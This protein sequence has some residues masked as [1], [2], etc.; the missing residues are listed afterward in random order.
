MPINP[1]CLQLALLS[2]GFLAVGYV[3]SGSFY[4][5]E[6]V[7]FVFG[8]GSFI[9]GSNR[10]YLMLKRDDGGRSILATVIYSPYLLLSAILMFSSR[11][12]S[13]EPAYVQ[14]GP[15]LYFGR[16]MTDHEV[17]NAGWV[18]I[19]DLAVE[20]PAG[21][22]QR[23][24]PGYRSMPLLDGGMFCYWSFS[25]KPAEWIEQ[26]V[27]AGPTYVHCALGHGRSAAVII[28]HWLATKQVKSCAEGLRKLQTLRPGVKLNGH[29][30]FHVI[31][32]N[33]LRRFSKRSELT[34]C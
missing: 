28:D 13:R 27:K 2:I 7:A 14:V 29:Q 1:C 3:W 12:L 9:F 24:L 34:L 31:H 22:W 26:S 6:C 20:F 17:R 15:N 21:A 16:R 30:R 25:E 33:R 23:T 5:F 10:P 19:L 18:N 11:R 32:R 8:V 4:I